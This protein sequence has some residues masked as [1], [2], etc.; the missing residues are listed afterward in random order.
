MMNEQE[1]PNI[2][3]AIEYFTILK[4]E[5]E[6]IT[7]IALVITIVILIILATVSVNVLFSEEGL[8]G[9]VKTAQNM[10]KLAEENEQIELAKVTVA[11]EH[12]GKLP[13]NQYIETLIQEHITTQE[14]VAYLENGSAQV[15]TKMNR[16]LKIEVDK[17]GYVV[18]I[19]QQGEESQLLASIDKVQ[20][21]EK[22]SSIKVEI[23]VTKAENATYKYFYKEGTGE[24]KKVY[25]GS[26]LTSTI[27][28]LKSGTEYWVKVEV[29]NENGTVSKEVLGKTK[30]IVKGQEG[31]VDVKIT[32][33]NERFENIK[34][35]VI[36]GGFLGETVTEEV[37][38]KEIKAAGI[39]AEENI[40][41]NSNNNYEMIT[42]EGY[43]YEVIFISASDISIN[44]I[45]KVQ[46]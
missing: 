25:E 30:E 31:I 26:N 23:E 14:N 34:T 8:I 13:I 28:K 5:K 37:L 27:E 16:T 32:E 7:L 15:T 42:N 10:H 9:K 18:A 39:V 6:G 44:Y 46:K 1:N 38:M 2:K 36:M 43:V 11:I 17:Q 20:L 21:T 24:Y 3:Q 22:T 4:K 40:M 12:K 45:G 29:M 33:Y 19:T 35:G 41:R